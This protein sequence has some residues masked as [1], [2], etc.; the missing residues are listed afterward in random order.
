MND[1]QSIRLYQDAYDMIQLN[2]ATTG[3]SVT[4]CPAR[5]GIVTSHVVRGRELLYLDKHTFLDPNANIRG[6]IPVL[7]PISGQLQNGEYVWNGRTY[8]MR[9]HGVAR[10]E[11]WEVLRTGDAGTASVTLGLTSSPATLA[12]YPF[13]FELEFTYLLK[14]GSLHILQKYRNLSREA[15]PMYPG[16]HPY[17]IADRKAIAY[18]TDAARIHDYNDHQDKPYKGSVD[19]GGL[20]ESVAFLDAREAAIAF[21]PTDRTIRL[22]YSDAFKYIILWSVEG[23]PFVCVEPWMALTGE[24][25]RRQELV[26]VEPG[27][28]FEAELAITCE[29]T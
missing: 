17:F 29:E 15:M 26:M 13:A 9:N 10:T 6:G 28:T 11:P 24:L 14:D 3:S 1:P 4:L 19:L 8:Q 21:R 25:N 27:E 20:V 16:F 23:K 5:G 12:S 7:F 18:A 2:E 22:R